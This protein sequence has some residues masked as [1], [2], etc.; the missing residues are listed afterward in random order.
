MFRKLSMLIVVGILGCAT[1]CDRG[2]TQP[3]TPSSSTSSAPVPRAKPEV[4][5]AAIPSAAGIVSQKIEG[6]KGA[7]VVVI[8]E[9]H[10]SRA[11]QLES[12]LVLVQLHQKFGLKHILLEGYLK[13]D[14]S[15]NDLKF[16]SALRDKPD[17]EKARFA[18][19]LVRE[20]DI[21]G[22][23]FMKVVFDD[24]VIHPAEIAEEYSSDTHT[25]EAIV[26]PLYLAHIALS[27]LDEEQIPKV[28][29]Y[30]AKLNS[31]AGT[32]KT[33]QARAMLA[34]SKY[35]I[36]LD[37]WSRDK[38]KK[39]QDMLTPGKSLSI[40][41]E[42]DFYQSIV[43]HGK[44]IKAHVQDDIQKEMDNF[45]TF[46]KK[47]AAASKT[48]VEATAAVADLPEVPLVAVNIG[49]GHTATVCNLLKGAGRPY[50]LISPNSLRDK[51]GRSDMSYDM[52]ERKYAGKPVVADPL[53]NELL[54]SFPLQAEATTRKNKP[55][56]VVRQ[57]WFQ[58]KAELY[59]STDSIASAL[60]GGGGIKPPKDGST[61]KTGGGGPG[62]SGGKGGGPGGDGLP[63]SGGNPPPDQPRGVFLALDDKARKEIKDNQFIYI[64]PDTIEVL[65]SRNGHPQEVLFKAVINPNDSTHRKEVWIKAAKAEG[66]GA[67]NERPKTIEEVIEKDLEGVK[68]EKP[69]K[70]RTGDDPTAPHNE[71][72]AR[73]QIGFDTKAIV[74][75][76]REDALRTSIRY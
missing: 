53:A 28:E 1:A 60:S 57:E 16:S 5:A 38:L 17:L 20:G 75:S 32:D 52:L 64:D 11:G 72:V 45:L 3:G 4:I 76:T 36:S 50:V 66:F 65:P 8:E 41:E 54:E 43:N 21:S 74:A 10:G 27:S 22:V 13:E 9:T 31:Q 33:K 12:A 58:A 69:S 47:R 68:K 49:A 2:P 55:K 14:P 35:V 40:E 42:V 7:P 23:E 63:P 39:Y 29:A 44:E 48:I 56:P 67:E 25:S 61:V 26:L 24:I 6:A 34:F 62:G 59:S 19:R 37:P 51:T 46:L 15:L 30:S 70:S 71:K 73:I 18:S